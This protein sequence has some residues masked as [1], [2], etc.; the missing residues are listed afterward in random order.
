MNQECIFCYEN[1]DLIDNN[2]CGCKYKY[3]LKCYINW[4]KD[5]DPC[6]CIICNKNFEIDDFKKFIDIRRYVN[7][8]DIKYLNNDDYKLYLKYKLENTIQDDVYFSINPNELKESLVN[9]LEFRNVLFNIVWEYNNPSLNYTKIGITNVRNKGIIYYRV[10]KNGN[11]KTN[12][13]SINR[14]RH[15]NHKKKCIIL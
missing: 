3:H 15:K 6:K 8:V 11:L 10:L 12:F 7:T 9:E 4:I 5:N 14:F 2:L 13:K 1:N